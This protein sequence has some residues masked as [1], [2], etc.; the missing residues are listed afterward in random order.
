MSADLPEGTVPSAWTGTSNI[1]V[2]PN[3]AEKAVD[4]LWSLGRQDGRRGELTVWYADEPGG[5]VATVRLSLPEGLRPSTLS[6]FPWARWMAVASAGARYPGPP[7]SDAAETDLPGAVNLLAAVEAARRQGAS[8]G[9][10][11]QRR[12]GRRPL[13]EGHYADVAKRYAELRL[14][15]TRNPTATIAAER[16]VNRNTVA[17]WLRGARQRGYLPPAQPGKAG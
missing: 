15:G 10:H 17:G 5:Q 14:Q 4:V 6:R 1:W 8:P 7:G 9:T 3:W 16:A 12:A 13:P 2:H 11:R